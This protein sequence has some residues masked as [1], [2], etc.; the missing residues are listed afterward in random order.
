VIKGVHFGKKWKH[1]VRTAQV[2]LKRKRADLFGR[3]VLASIEDQ[4]T[5]RARM[6]SLTDS[7][8]VTADETAV[9]ELL[10][11]LGWSA[12]RGTTNRSQS[13]GGLRSS[14]SHRRH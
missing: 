9:E 10:S 14:T 2:H 12:Y 5:V 4:L 7:Q 8:N 6:K 11:S 3:R 13:E 1:F